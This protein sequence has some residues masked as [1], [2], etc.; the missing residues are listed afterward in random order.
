MI[1]Q[2]KSPRDPFLITG[3][4][5]IDD[6]VI[7]ATLGNDIEDGNFGEPIPVLGTWE[8]DSQPIG[9]T[10][11]ATIAEKGAQEFRDKVV[12]A[13]VGGFFLIAPMWFMVLRNDLYTSLVSTTAFVAAFGIIMAWN[14]DKPKEVIAGTA[15]Y[16]A[17]LVVFVG[18][19]STT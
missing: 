10:R 12:M 7:R 16:A 14:L 5:A 13:T 19:G 18:T 3:E 8:N 15:A 6:F 1:Q 9:G 2:A 4:R 17:V 11:T